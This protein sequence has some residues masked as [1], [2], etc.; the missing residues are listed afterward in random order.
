MHVLRAEKGFIVVGQETDGTVTPDDLGLSRTIA[1]AKPD[2]VGKRSLLRSDMLRVDRKQLVGLL[3][4][5][6]SEVLEEGAQV[7]ETG[8]VSVGHVTSS[9]FSATLERSIALGM[10]SGGRTRIGHKSYVS[11]TD[12]RTEVTIVDPVFY[13]PAGARMTYA[14]T[15]SGRSEHV[16]V[17]K[18]MDLPPARMVGDARLTNV[19]DTG[20]FS[21]RTSTPLAPP[22]RV[23]GN[24]LWL[25]P[26][27]VPCFR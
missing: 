26:D 7:T 9:Y 24:A 21:V 18:T 6:P 10:V 27:D 19:P 17:A 15:P 13:D 16:L 5:D 25:G 22:L 4:S 2:F 14:I 1:R 3:T 20:K 23:N 12:R 8:T 11:M